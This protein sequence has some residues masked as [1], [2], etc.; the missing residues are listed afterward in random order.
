M[1]RLICPCLNVSVS[2]SHTDGNWNTRPVEARRL[3]PERSKDR[4]VSSH[5]KLYEVDL[6]VAGVFAVSNVVNCDRNVGRWLII[7]FVIADLIQWNPRLFLII[8]TL[9][10]VPPM[11]LCSKL[12]L[13]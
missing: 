11:E 3:F 4:L 2:C 9:F 6:D 7:N 13:E 12:T 10:M 5:S 1:D 8:R